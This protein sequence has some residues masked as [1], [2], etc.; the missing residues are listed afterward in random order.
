MRATIPTGSNIYSYL[1]FI[2][3]VR[4]S[5]V[6]FRRSHG[7]SRVLPNMFREGALRGTCDGSKYIAQQHIWE[8]LTVG[9]VLGSLIETADLADSSRAG[10]HIAQPLVRKIGGR[11]A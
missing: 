4:T 2:K 3:L 1:T 10:V 7:G 11:C 8:P 5:S 9:L 6:D